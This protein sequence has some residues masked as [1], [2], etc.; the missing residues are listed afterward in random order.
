MKKTITLLA[1]LLAG[2]MLQAQAVPMALEDW[3]T[4]QGTQ[5][6]FYKNV[7]K[8][9]ASGN[10][11]VAGATMNAGFPDMLVAKYNSA[12]NLQWIRQIA[13][14]A[15]NGVDAIAG[16]Y[17]SNTDVYVTGVVS[18]NSVMPETDCITMKLSGST[19][20]VLWSA[21]YTGVAGSHDA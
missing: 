7:T 4:T 2:S 1:C 12:G 10:V 19:G 20:A 3:K 14:T 11:Y 6:F 9:D 15:P 21:T 16:M 8:T 13:G 5:N 18:D 17:V